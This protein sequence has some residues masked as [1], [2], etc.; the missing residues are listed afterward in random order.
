MD[1]SLPKILADFAYR[2]SFKDLSPEVVEKA[3]ISILDA[4]GCAFDGYQVETSQMALQVLDEVIK[5]GKA[6]LWTNGRKGSYSDIAWANC[7][8]VHSVL[9]DDTQ[10]SV[11]GHL[12]SMIIP[13]AF[14]VGEHLEKSGADVITAMV[15]AYEVAGRIGQ[16]SNLTIVGRGFRGSGIFGPFASTV[17]AGKLMGLDA[18]GLQSAIACAS[19]FSAGI[20]EASNTGTLEW[21]FHNGAATRN[22]II[23]ALLAKHGLR[24]TDSSLEGERGFFSTF[25]GPELRKE[26]LKN[27][28]QITATLGKEFEISKNMFKPYATCGYNQT[29]VDIA[30]TLAKQNGIQPKEIKGVEIQVSPDNKAYPGGDRHPPFNTLDQALLSKP[31][32]IGAAVKNKELQG[33]VYATQLSDPEIWAVAEKVTTEA[34][35]GMDPMAC[36]VKFILADGRTIEGDD[37]SIDSLNYSLNRE[38]V[39]QKF[40][41]LTS[42]IL[43]ADL[44][45]RIAQAAFKIQDMKRVSEFTGLLAR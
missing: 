36:K 24:A 35:E 4:L 28:D 6:T 39:I 27:R 26:M 31:F 29:G 13:T 43:P 20:L 23:A 41:K 34:V 10:W 19:N 14:A 30:I 37:S 5:D 38:L 11:L 7:L 17:A 18:E 3:Q 12:G 22:G 40:Q 33:N 32:S 9:H 45:S 2:L 42:A 8:L 1:D 16:Q 44:S 15:A 21:R 25:G